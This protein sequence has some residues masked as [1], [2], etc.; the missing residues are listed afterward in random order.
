MICAAWQGRLVAEP[1]VISSACLRTLRVMLDY[2][3]RTCSPMSRAGTLP[4][5]AEAKRN[6]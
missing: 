6:S 1:M 5:Y 2:M 4:L 3:Q